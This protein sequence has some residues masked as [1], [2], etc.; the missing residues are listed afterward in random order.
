MYISALNVMWDKAN[1]YL[2]DIPILSTLLS[3]TT[4]IPGVGKGRY[5]CKVEEVNRTPCHPEYELE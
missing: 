1:E 2:S 5:R 4:R 3:L